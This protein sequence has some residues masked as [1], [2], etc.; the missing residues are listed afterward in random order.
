VLCTVECFSCDNKSIYL[1][2]YKENETGLGAHHLFSVLKGPR[3][4]NSRMSHFR[5][6]VPFSGTTR[7]WFWIWWMPFFLNAQSDLKTGD[8]SQIAFREFHN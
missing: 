7:I 4:S 2:N 5:W 6:Y 8:P 1:L 3:Q